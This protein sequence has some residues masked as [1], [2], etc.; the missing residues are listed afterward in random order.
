MKYYFVINPAAGPGTSEKKIREQL[1]GLN[2]LIDCEMYI[3]KPD[4]DTTNFVRKTIEENPDKEL[5]F[6]AC[7]GDGTINE[8]FEACA[9]KD[10]VYVSCFPNGSGND[11][12]K[13]YGADNFTVEGIIHGT[14][15]KIDI[16]R[17]ED[18]NCVNVTNFGIDTS[19][20]KT[21]NEGRAK[22]GH[23]SSL[24]YPK[25]VV[26]AIFTSMKTRCKIIADG[27]LLNPEGEVLSVTLA[28]GQ[29]VGGSYHCSPRAKLDDG[30]MDICIIKPI[31]I[32][33]F[34]Q[35]IGVYSKGEHLDN[36]KISKYLIYR[37]AKEVEV[38]AE[39][40]FEYTIDGEIVGSSHFFCKVEPLALNFIA[41]EVKS[42]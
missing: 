7:G 37:Q 6:I 26:K 14:K 11:F 29:Y 13:N 19:V 21:V 39:D 15:T 33:K 20:A 25:G 9:H 27:E 42:R 12:V 38:I 24:D 17:V 16:I 4:K 23:G 32:I 36:E 1:D 40:G 30:L 22:R 35:F 5:C 31:N 2:E 34:A 28:N 10:N 18:R 3:T 41:P 8:V